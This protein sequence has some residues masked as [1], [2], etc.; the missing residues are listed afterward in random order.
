M[1]T[2]FV[3]S[4]YYRAVMQF[5]IGQVH[6]IQY[7]HRSISEDAVCQRSRSPADGRSP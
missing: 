3:G 1:M 7:R 6:G 2:H 4:A 5:N